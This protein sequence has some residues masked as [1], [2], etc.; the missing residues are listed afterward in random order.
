MQFWRYGWKH[1]SCNKIRANK[2][3]YVIGD[4]TEKKKKK[5]MK[6]SKA[7]TSMKRKGKR[8]SAKCK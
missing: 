2:A 4:D 8:S 5:K 3:E 7:Q 6:A 1:L